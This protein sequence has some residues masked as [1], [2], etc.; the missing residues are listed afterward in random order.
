VAGPEPRLGSG[1][2]GGQ[3]DKGGL[4]QPPLSFRP[5]V[6]P[7][8]F[9][10][11]GR[12]GTSASRECVIEV[13]RCRA[14]I[15][16]GPLF[17]KTVPTTIRRLRYVTP[18]WNPRT[19]ASQP[20]FLLQLFNFELFTAILTAAENSAPKKKSGR[21]GDRPLGRGG[22]RVLQPEASS[23]LPIV[24]LRSRAAKRCTGAIRPKPSYSGSRNQLPITV[25]ILLSTTL[26]VDSPTGSIF[27]VL[28]AVLARLF[29]VP[30]Y[31]FQA[32]RCFSP[33][34]KA[35]KM[36]YGDSLHSESVCL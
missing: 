7:L 10:V 24:S 20:S 35:A 22:W 2:L 6:L 5:V 1:F 9:V 25:A 13:V 33:T 31:L 36:S 27:T 26:C 23:V 11:V 30:T 15:H 18:P 17:F 16:S 29:L 14:R 19:D 34:Y 3:F 28:P 21:W 8:L 4:H 32:I 12:C